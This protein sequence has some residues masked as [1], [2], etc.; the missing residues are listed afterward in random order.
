M[1]YQIFFLPQVKKIGIISNKHGICELPHELSNDVKRRIL[2]NY[3]ISIKSQ[4]LIE[5]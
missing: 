3:E 5:L 4:K 1:F 2:G